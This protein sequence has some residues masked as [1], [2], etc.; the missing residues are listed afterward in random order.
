MLSS[1]S[2]IFILMHCQGY[3][4][5]GNS[6]SPTPPDD[7]TRITRL[8]D[9]SKVS[10]IFPDLAGYRNT[11]IQMTPAPVLAK[12]SAAELGEPKIVRC[13]LNLDE[14]WD[15]RTRKFDF[16]FIIGVDK[17]K[18][19]QAKYR[20]SWNWETESNVP[21]ESYLGAFSKNSHAIMLD[22]RRYERDILDHRLPITKQD[23]KMIFK[24]GLEHYKRLFPNIRYVEVANE[25]RGKSFMAATDEEYYEFYKLGYEAVAEVNRELHLT[26]E[27]RILVGGPVVTG[28]VLPAIDHFLQFYSQDT[29]R[30]KH[31]DFISWHDY[32][33]PIDQT[34]YRQ[35]DITTLLKKYKLNSD[36]PLFMTEHDPFHKSKDLP[37]YHT[38]NAAYLPKSLYFSSVFSPEVRIFPWVL[39]H[40][41]NIQTK[42]MWFEGPNKVDTKARE[43][44]MLP[45][46]CSMKF[47]SMLVGKQIVIKNSI[48]GGDLI[49]GAQTKDSIVVETINY[50]GK[51]DVDI[52]L[53]RIGEVFSVG[54]G[55]KV[56][57]RKYLID[58][59][60]S[61]SLLN[62]NYKGGIEEISNQTVALQKGGL[63]L[64][65]EGL[66]Q[67]A[68]I[69]WVIKPEN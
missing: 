24:T 26:G 32:N 62:S 11:S 60:H 69:L 38:M 30:N 61:N 35:T 67:Y 55:A 34:S 63:T 59:T 53:R 3:S 36:I 19:I 29:S 48:D 1:V 25:Y 14:M 65:Q 31:L 21:F 58:S 57:I 40:N 42:F 49:L 7:T 39:Y 8:I 54:K 51:K 23:W 16:N 37:I 18:D 6:R 12:L 68:L 46:G 20:E 44:T 17:Y 47:L 28:N 13:W 27:N 66:E 5:T 50:A 41:K 2:L 64:R 56:R 52:R 33:K 4:S 45:I 22:I 43:L 15:Y 9:V 10:G